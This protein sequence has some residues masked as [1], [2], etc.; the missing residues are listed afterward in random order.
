[1]FC[2]EC[3]YALANGQAYVWMNMGEYPYKEP[4]CLECAMK[5]DLLSDGQTLRVYDARRGE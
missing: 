5:M 1:M 2:H 4:W 3:D